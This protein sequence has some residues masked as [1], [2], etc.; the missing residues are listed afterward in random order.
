MAAD[1]AGRPR[2]RSN[3]KG[4]DF[5][6]RLVDGL[7]ERGIPPLATLYHWDLPQALEDEGG[8][9]TRD[10]VEPFAEYADI[11]A[12]GLGDRVDDWITHNEPWVI[13]V[14]RLRVRRQGAG[15]AG[16]AAALAAAHHVLLA[17]GVAVQ[18]F[19]GPCRHRT[20][21][22][23]ARP[24][25]RRA[26]DGTAPRTRDAAE[27]LDGHHNR[28]FLD[29]IFKGAYPE[30]VLAWYESRC[31][32]LDVIRPGDLEVIS[33]PLDFLGV[34]FYRPEPRRGRRRRR[35][36]SSS[37]RPIAT[38]SAPRWAGRSCPAP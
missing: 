16:L 20:D 30:D 11:V 9:A 35:H 36:R 12:R 6:R 34:N 25:R 37:A 8:W 18:T 17:H 19:R 33:E 7:L 32:S 4:L 10:I 24:H 14:P 29:P 2:R 3:Q 15:R 23:H 38:P 26:G 27:R 31:G 28:W 21:R 1:P 5:Y 22:H 13:V